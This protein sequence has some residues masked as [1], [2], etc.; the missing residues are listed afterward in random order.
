MHA[1]VAKKVEQA[2]M[3]RHRGKHRLSQRAANRVY[4][5]AQLAAAY[6]CIVRKTKWWPRAYFSSVYRINKPGV[7]RRRSHRAGNRLARF[8]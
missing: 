3:V 7:L 8:V 5:L 1:R 2:A 4:N 6:R